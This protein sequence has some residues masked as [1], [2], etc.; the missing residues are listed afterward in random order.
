MADMGYRAASSVW[1]ASASKAHASPRT[2]VQV[3]MERTAPSYMYIYNIIADTDQR[4]RNVKTRRHQGRGDRIGIATG[5]RVYKRAPLSSFVDDSLHSLAS[6]GVPATR[7]TSFFPT[8]T[9]LGA[10]RPFPP[11]IPFL[12]TH[13]RPVGSGDALITRLTARVRRS[14]SKRLQVGAARIA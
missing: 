13:V 10:K 14:A 7:G 4:R 1:D 9:G 5:P 8:S 11:R 6:L 3:Y 2:I 12:S